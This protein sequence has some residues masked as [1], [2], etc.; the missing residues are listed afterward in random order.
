M[1]G[2]P[3]D[4][5][6]RPLASELKSAAREA[7]AIAD[8]VIYDG[9]TF[10]RRSEVEKFASILDSVLIVMAPGESRELDIVST[11]YVFSEIRRGIVGAALNL[12]EREAQRCRPDKQ[13]AATT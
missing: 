11:N 2:S 6:Y 8:L 5:E 7:A 13:Q 3:L 1:H 9:G 4:P 10:S 12:D